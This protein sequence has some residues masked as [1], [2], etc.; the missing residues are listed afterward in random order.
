MLCVAQL[1]APYTYRSNDNVAWLHFYAECDHN[2]QHELLFECIRNLNIFARVCGDIKD[3]DTTS[4]GLNTNF[5]AHL[6]DSRSTVTSTCP[7]YT[8]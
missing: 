2:M 5:L 6:P 7:A 1:L 8:E 4:T 3:A